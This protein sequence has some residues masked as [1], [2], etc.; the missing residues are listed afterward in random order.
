MVSHGERECRFCQRVL[1]IQV[2]GLEPLHQ[3]GIADVVG[4][5]F[6]QHCSER[7]VQHTI[8]HHDFG[9]ERKV[10]WMIAPWS[11]MLEVEISRGWFGRPARDRYRRNT[12]LLPDRR[13][14]FQ[15][16][17]RHR[18]G[19]CYHSAWCPASD[20]SVPP[21]PDAPTI[22]EP[23][24]SP[25]RHGQ[26][27]GEGLSCS[28]IFHHSNPHIICLVTDHLTAFAARSPGELGTARKGVAD[29]HRHIQGPLLLSVQGNGK[30]TCRTVRS[31]VV[32]LVEA[33]RLLEGLAHI[34][35]GVCVV[36]RAAGM[37]LS[38]EQWGL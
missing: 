22:R 6:P 13:M 26:Y 1:P 30:T 36:F 11:A 19:Q 16:L 8:S 28:Y 31:A 20:G 32:S 2:R 18:T 7:T 10:S 33:C 38:K 35:S 14:F 27:L 3:A 17:S 23:G 37:N 25:G 9:E 15:C 12:T 29:L 24:A 34:G 21:V 4:F 5:S